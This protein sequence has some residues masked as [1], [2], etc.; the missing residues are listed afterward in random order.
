MD[1]QKGQLVSNGTCQKTGSR[2]IGE[3]TQRVL[4][5]IIRYKKMNDGNSPPRRVLAGIIGVSSLS[6][7]QYHIRIL[8]Q[9]GLI[10]LNDAGK[11]LIPGATWLSPMTLSSDVL[12]YLTAF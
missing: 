1:F 11:I 9:E 3:K 10:R 5:E 12:F 2:G 7:V 4:A 8:E 6:T